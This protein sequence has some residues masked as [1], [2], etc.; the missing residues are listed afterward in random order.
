MNM[1]LHRD[2]ALRQTRK[3]QA[4]ILA[5]REAFRALMG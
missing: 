5:E 1:S 4:E 2:E 3:L